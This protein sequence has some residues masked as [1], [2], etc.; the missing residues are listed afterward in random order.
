ME[1]PP[2]PLFFTFQV[3]KYI[4]EKKSNKGGQTGATHLTSS[5]GK[6]LLSSM[7]QSRLGLRPLHVPHVPSCL[8]LQRPTPKLLSPAVS[9]SC[10]SRGR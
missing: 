4:L 1:P 3:N 10:V 6:S 2:Q 7:E 8:V 9:S 5:L